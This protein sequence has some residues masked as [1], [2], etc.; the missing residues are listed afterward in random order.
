MQEFIVLSSLDPALNRNRKYVI[1]LQID[2]D[3]THVVQGWGRGSRITATKAS[4]FD[5][6]ALAHKYINGLLSRR[7]RNG[8]TVNRFSS[9]FDSFVKSLGLELQQQQLTLQLSLFNAYN[10]LPL[11]QSA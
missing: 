8:Y 4:S 11:Q 5:S 3:Q 7:N 1:Y 10:T 6:E 2:N 9:Y